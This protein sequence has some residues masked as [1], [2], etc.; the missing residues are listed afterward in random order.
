MT[1]LAAGEADLAEAASQLRAFLSAVNSPSGVPEDVEG[2][3][4]FVQQCDFLLDIA[5]IDTPRSS[6]PTLWPVSGRAAVPPTLRL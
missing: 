5:E 2:G 4:A 3:A 1:K 6:C